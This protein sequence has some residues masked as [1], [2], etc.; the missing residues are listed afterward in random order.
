MTVE[1][2]VAVRPGSNKTIVIGAHYDSV[3]RSPGA[4]DNASG[5]AGVLELAKR[6]CRGKGS[7][8]IFILFS[9]EEQGLVGSRYWVKNNKEKIDFMINLDMIGHYRGS[10]IGTGAS[11]QSS[12]NCETVFIHTGQNKYYHQ[13]SDVPD[14]LDYDGIDKVID[15]CLK[16][17]DD[18]DNGYNLFGE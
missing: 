8:I 1:N 10:M 18:S 12:F 2:I 4:D 3:S 9:G 14:T 7:K 16:L 17:I 15:Y 6:A 11:D 5:V 13:P